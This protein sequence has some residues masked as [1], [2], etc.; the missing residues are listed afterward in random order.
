VLA[1]A[2]P[3]AAQD[4]KMEPGPKSPQDSLKCIKTRPGFKVELMVA[5]PLV[6]SPI[7]FAWGPDGKFWVVEMGDYPL[8]LDGKGKPGGNIKYLEKSKPDGPYDKMTLFMSGLGFPTG[9]FPYKNGVLV[10]CAPDIFYAEV[11][12]DGKAAKKEILFTGFKE[13]NQQHRVNG[14]TWGI[15]NWIY[16]A[17][18]DS[19]GVVKSIKTGKSVNI[20][21]RDF[22]LKPDTGEFE[23]VSG[24][25]Q[26]G[27]CRDD[28]GNWF[29]CNNSNPMYH[30]VLE[31][32]YL[33]RNPHVL[34]PDPRVP[35]SVKPG[36]AEVFPISRPLPRF[37]SPQALNHFTSACSTIIYRDT[38][39][40]KEFEGNMFVSE[41][42]HN[43]VHR[44]IMKPKGVTFTSQRADDEQTSE[45]LASSD[46]WF[47]P[48]MIQVGPDGALWIADMY[49]Y[50]I[51]HPEWIPKDWQKKLDLRAGH[52]SGRIYRV[53]PEGKKPREIVRLDK[54]KVEEL[55][56]QLEHPN[57]WVRDAA[58][59]LLV[60][61]GKGKVMQIW[62]HL[63][64]IARKSKVP[65]ARLHAL[66]YHASGNYVG[67][68]ETVLFDLSRYLHDPHP[69][70]RSHVIAMIEERLGA[71]PDHDDLDGL[72]RDADPQVRQQLAQSLSGQ[73]IAA[74]RSHGKRL[75][76]I[77]LNNSDNPYVVAS[78]L[79]SISKENWKELL[80]ELK[81]REQ[82]PAT[83]LV[84]L[85][86]MARNIGHPLDAA[87]IF[88]RQL[89]SSEK[90][91]STT[92]ITSVG[93]MLDA[94]EKNNLTLAKLLESSGQREVEKT[95]AKLKDIHGEAVKVVNN[96]KSG[97]ADKML[98]LRLLG[99]GLGNDKEDH[100]ILLAMLTPQTPDDVQ[101]AVITQLS[102]QFDPRVPGLLLAPWKTYSPKLRGQVLDT[103]FSRPLWTKMTID[104]IKRKEIPAAEIDAIRRQRLLGHKD[105]DIRAMSAKLF[106][107]SSSPDRGKVV[108]VYWLQLPDK[109]DAVRG[110]KLFAKAC[111]TCHK[112]GA[113]GQNVGPD[114]ASVG[115]K[116]V[117][118]LLTAIL[119]PNRA[120]EPRYVNYLATTKSGK[121]LNGIIAGETSTSITLVGPDGKEQ[122]LL[123]NEID[124]LASSG[125]SLMPDGLE[126][127][128]T[129]Q[130]VADIIALVRSNQSAPK[131][132]PFPGNEPTTIKAD[133]EGI[134]RLFPATAAVFGKTL[135]IEEKYGNLG[136]WSSPDDHAVWTI[137][138]PK[139][140]KYAVW[141]Y[142]AC[143]NDSA[144]NTLTLEAGKERL[145]YKVV[146]TGTWDDYRGQNLG[147][148]QLSAG[149]QEITIRAEGVIRGVLGDVKKVE[150]S[151]R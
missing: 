43:L 131:R 65:Q 119:D 37:N 92:L 124:E 106:A 123:R 32:R 135:V 53:Y 64:P 35:V 122:Q 24:Q 118:G 10:T 40:G 23:A 148:V 134:F 63:E 81:T 103:L 126:K 50:V 2:I 87:Q 39:F 113:V 41:P 80:A 114:L 141:V 19:G 1:F 127:D 4:F 44:E 149:K 125:K 108:D 79:T 28:W 55:V 22:R 89:S 54:M 97:M 93:D 137:D 67:W 46:N 138:V 29:G 51:E 21:G 47:R 116:S 48:T 150:L 117:Q 102:R 77:L 17:N 120:V 30:Y 133:K 34:Y 9:V 100:K 98:A 136:F 49:R 72:E 146:G 96:P 88:T 71:L 85:M 8:G 121:T 16:G 140:G 84:S 6:K 147:D 107:I 15:D 3:A 61:Q 90:Q 69:A 101:G 110:A 112:L 18:G 12:K 95:L 27:R 31:D 111:A 75:A 109:T 82:L 144:G 7:A 91:T 78:G 73:T 56:K 5:E 33:K 104:A 14:L 115:D 130:D 142:Y 42:V 25:S 83:L 128:L 26:F 70:I 139:A 57:G 143:A 58:H 68:G 13:G 20:S 52:D 99:Q 59:Q 74:E 105:A 151:P 45:F 145:T 62:E 129:P 60:A 76:R 36:A 66:Y 38:L 94:I 86:R 132:K 11:G